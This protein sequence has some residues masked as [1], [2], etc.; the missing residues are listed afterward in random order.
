M[1]EYFMTFQFCGLRLFIEFAN[2][3]LKSLLGVPTQISVHPPIKVALSHP[4]TSP[5]V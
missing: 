5:R 4:S 2:V 1:Q 3:C